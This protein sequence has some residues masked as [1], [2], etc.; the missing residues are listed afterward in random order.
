[1]SASNKVTSN[2]G[3]QNKNS[4]KNQFVTKIIREAFA[5]LDNS[6]A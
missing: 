3:Q 4:L 1:M 5:S 6:P 2:N